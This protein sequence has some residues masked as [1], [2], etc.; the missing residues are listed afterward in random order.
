MERYKKSTWLQGRDGLRKNSDREQD[1]V[2]EKPRK[3]KKATT[4]SGGRDGERKNTGEEEKKAQL[5]GQGD[6]VK[7]DRRNGKQERK[8]SKSKQSKGTAREK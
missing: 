8:D 6:T 5:A 2:T 7:K 1:R 3:K 4:M